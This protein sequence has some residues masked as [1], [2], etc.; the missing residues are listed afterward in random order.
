MEWYEN[1]KLRSNKTKTF[2]KHFHE[3]KTIINKSFIHYDNSIRKIGDGLGKLRSID[4]TWIDDGNK[5]YYEFANDPV[6]APKYSDGVIKY[7][8]LFNNRDIEIHFEP[9]CEHILGQISNSNIVYTNAFGEGID[10]ILEPNLNGLKKIVKITAANKEVKEYRFKFKLIFKNRISENLKLYSISNFDKTDYYEIQLNNNTILINDYDR[11]IAFGK[12]ADNA[13][14]IPQPKVW[15]TPNSLHEIN[16]QNIDFEIQ[17]DPV[18]SNYYLEKIIP[19][20]YIE[21]SNGDVYTDTEISIDVVESSII[22]SNVSFDPAGWESVYTGINT[23]LNATQS[24]SLGYSRMNT[25]QG[26]FGGPYQDD[27]V[28]SWW[29]IDNL[30]GSTIISAEIS[31]TENSSTSPIG[32]WDGDVSNY[33]YWVFIDSTVEIYNSSNIYGNTWFSTNN[34]EISDT[35]SMI[36]SDNET[37]TLSLNSNG[38][39]SLQNSVNDQDVEWGCMF[40]SGFSANQI[41]PTKTTPP[42]VAQN[43]QYSY[44][45]IGYGTEPNLTVTYSLEE[46]PDLGG[47]K[48]VTTLVTMF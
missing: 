1:K 27:R 5:Y 6:E 4:K 30:H 12:T 16:V 25:V 32:G 18:T 2:Q 42:G 34:T 28:L 43:S 48:G 37:L 46:S 20:S 44:D 19:S 47:G 7:N 3:R 40:S 26:G 11:Y 15:D 14:V 38:I 13:T 10:L 8:D 29:S 22:L 36:R 9:V 33:D 24:S 35:A 17:W 21:T 23:T 41:A 39:N 31:I 45:A